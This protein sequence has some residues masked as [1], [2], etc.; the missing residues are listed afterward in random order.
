MSLGL[1]NVSFSY[2]NFPVLERVSWALPEQGVVCLWGASGCGKTTLLRLLAGLE[3]PLAGVVHRPRALSMMFQEDRLLPRCRAWENVAVATG[4]D[5]PASVAALA[6]VGLAEEA[7][8][9]PDAL[10]GGQRRRVA[11]ARALAMPGE[12]MLL[13]EPF[14]G[15]D[16]DT[17]RA[18][19]PAIL[20][21]AAK[22]PVVLVTHVAEEAQALNA[23]RI[24][25]EKTPLCGTLFSQEAEA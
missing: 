17:W 18:A 15:L 2:G 22:I 9:F 19:V 11:L 10:S 21:R 6:A 3:S 1:E 20:A 7:E 4:L 8:S 16:A 14:T 24:D 25:L 23:R 13:D 5:R 12:L